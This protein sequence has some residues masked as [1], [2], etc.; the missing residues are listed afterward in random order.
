LDTLSS[1]CYTIPWQPRKKARRASSVSDRDQEQPSFP[2]LAE[3]E[4]DSTPARVRYAAYQ[5]AIARAEDIFDRCVSDIFASLFQ[6][7]RLFFGTAT[8]T[9]AVEPPPNL[10]LADPSFYLPGFD[11][12]PLSDSP[13]APSGSIQTALLISSSAPGLATFSGRLVS[14]IAS[15]SSSE[16]SSNGADV[17]SSPRI[18]ITLTASEC[19]NLYTALRL[20]VARFIAKARHLASAPTTERDQSLIQIEAAALAGKVEPDLGILQHWWS[21]RFSGT[22]TKPQIVLNLPAIETI[23]PS[24][25]SD[26]LSSLQTF[27]S[28]SNT[29]HRGSE[30]MPK[31]TL[32]LGITSPS[33][34]LAAA[35]TGSSSSAAAP[36]PWIDYIPRQ[37]LRVLDISRFALP[38]REAVWSKLVQIFLVSRHLPLS[39]GPS[40]FEFIRQTYWERDADLDSVLEAVRLAYFIHFS[41]K[42]ESVFTIP[43]QA[44]EVRFFS[45]TPKMV[46]RIQ[47]SFLSADA[48]E[49]RLVFPLL[50]GESTGEAK[51]PSFDVQTF[52]QNIS[53]SNE[54]L[55]DHV[56]Q[57]CHPRKV[58]AFRTELAIRFLFGAF[59]A[60]QRIQSKASSAAQVI[61]A[62]HTTAAATAAAQRAAV[63]AAELEEQRQ[64]ER[65]G[66]ILTQVVSQCLNASVGSINAGGRAAPYA[67]QLGSG[68]G[69]LSNAARRLLSDEF[70]ELLDELVSVA[71]QQV[72]RI[73]NETSEATGTEL[74]EDDGQQAGQLRTANSIILTQSQNF[75]SGLRTFQQKLSQTVAAGTAGMEGEDEELAATASTSGAN[76]E[77]SALTPAQV[78]AKREAR[79]QRVQR[80]LL[81]EEKLLGLKR[82]I[83]DWIV[84]AVLGLVDWKTLLS[85][86]GGSGSL[87]L[88]K[89][90]FYVD[91]YTPLSTLLDP[92]IRANLTLPM[93]EPT[94]FLENLYDAALSV[95]PEEE[96]VGIEVDSLAAADVPD[97]CRIYQLY[98][99]CGKFVNLAD[100]FEA[101]KQSVELDNVV[102]SVDQDLRRANAQAEE[103]ARSLPATPKTPSKRRRTDKP[104]PR[105]P[106]LSQQQQQESPFESSATTTAT[107]SATTG[108]LG[109]SNIQGRFALALNELARMG[110]LRGTRRRAEHIT[111]VMWDLVPD[112]F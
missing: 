13:S 46:E 6:D 14:Q 96:L 7:L 34:G 51:Q 106:Q 62:R 31:L 54:F 89:D 86:D 79:L 20:L 44:K 67:L 17:K 84:R 52:L 80:K 55:M 85:I 111:K 41:G 108:P 73:E 90:I 60:L 87:R 58:L 35:A 47:L 15:S 105:V 93:S 82:E 61:R 24:V 49:H 29:S 112:T 26:L 70:E 78:Q 56:D 5:L 10:G 27:V 42:P 32:I 88:L 91:C 2:I 38:S 64:I 18:V 83:T 48:S 33:G 37:V 75:L 98:R 77:P 50:S 101:F 53:Q 68:L 66:E 99:E 3:F 92:S 81:M 4:A 40:T 71:E 28:G 110:M 16:R 100:W 45:W 104:H 12:A 65:A 25:F 36:A 97:I 39:L 63:Q 69:R 94:E 11:D 8:E 43:G 74:Q 95:V 109:N 107:G 1:T 30:Q 19:T 9:D 22:D 72:H 57:L 102:D 21:A 23:E 76:G 103:R 59:E